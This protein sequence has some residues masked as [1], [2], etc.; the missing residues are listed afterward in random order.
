LCP[1]EKRQ[2]STTKGGM[3]VNELSCKY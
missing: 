1:E 3:H 2:G